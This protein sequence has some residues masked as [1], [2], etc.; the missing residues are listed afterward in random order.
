MKQTDEALMSAIRDGDV[1]K[2]G[3][4]FDRHAKP[5]FEFFSRLT[6]DRGSSDDLVQDVF[7]RILKYR[8]TFRGDGKFTTWMYNIARNARID[9]FRKHRG[10]TALPEEPNEIPG[11]APFPSHELQK[12]QEAAT[13]KRA[14]Y[15]LSEEKREV[16]VLSRYQDMKYEQIAELLGCEIGTVK[17]RVHRAVKDLR[18]IYLKLSGEQRCNVKK[19][20]TNLRVI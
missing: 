19:P 20:E 9:H 1:A 16:L 6:G 17:G 15:M 11:S 18:E 8:Q 5:L 10:E 13:L 12:Q 3:I 4:L 7:F 14:L 2:L